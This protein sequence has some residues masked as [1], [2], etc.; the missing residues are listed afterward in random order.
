MEGITQLITGKLVSLSKQ[1]L[2]DCDVPGEDQ[3]CNCG[4]MDDAFK[5]IEQNKGLTTETNYPYD[6]IDGT[7]N[8]NKAANHAAKI[9][10]YEDVPANSESAL[11]KVKK[12]LLTNQSLWPLM[13]GVPTSNS[14]RVVSS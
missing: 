7:C 1:E 5:F 9:A 6:G 4:L 11:L 12:L 14:T 2:V 8:K 3:G 13:P 10:G